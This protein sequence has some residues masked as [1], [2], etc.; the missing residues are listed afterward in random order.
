M[1]SGTMDH[2]NGLAKT[3]A[4][5]TWAP[6]ARV[7]LLVAVAAFGL[8]SADGQILLES[9]DDGNVDEYTGV[10]KSN[11]DVPSSQVSVTAEAAH[12]GP[13]GLRYR[14]QFG[15]W[16]LRDDAAVHVEQGDVLSV[17]IRADGEPRGRGYFGFGATASGTLTMVMAPNTGELLLQVSTNRYN[18]FTDIGSA[19]QT[20]LADHWYRMEVTWETSGTITGCLYDSDGATLLN[21]VTATNTAITSGG[22]AFRSFESGKFFDTVQVLGEAPPVL[23]RKY[24]LF[25]VAR[26]LK[27]GVS[28]A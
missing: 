19:P 23:G 15:N 14:G 2:K 3:R 10:L 6:V 16:I 24:I 18:H 11:P 22:I 7:C 4:G 13:F 20:W 28:A 27:I 1:R 12:D 26:S 9:F 5:M 21:T 25:S 8:G 17:W